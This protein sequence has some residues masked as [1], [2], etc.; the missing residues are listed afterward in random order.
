MRQTATLDLYERLSQSSKAAP[1]SPAITTITHA[2]EASD[3]LDLTQQATGV[4]AR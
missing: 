2:E 4:P 3:K 1:P